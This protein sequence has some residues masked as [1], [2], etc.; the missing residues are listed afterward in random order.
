M[1]GKRQKGFDG[2]ERRDLVEMRR[3]IIGDE[4]I[5][6]LINSDIYRKVNFSKEI[7]L[8][9]CKLFHCVIFNCHLQM[10]EDFDF[11]LPFSSVIIKL[12]F[13]YHSLLLLLLLPSLSPF[14]SRLTSERKKFSKSFLSRFSAR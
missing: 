13:K 10:I 4:M 7:N 9:N 1:W 14:A 12:N 3:G 2:N 8:D 6:L 5:V 11:S